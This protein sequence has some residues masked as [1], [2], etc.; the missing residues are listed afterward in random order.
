MSTRKIIEDLIERL[1]GVAPTLLIFTGPALAFVGLLYLR[2]PEP[3]RASSEADQTAA[4]TND[5]ASVAKPTEA[6]GQI[7]MLEPLRPRIIRP[8]PEKAPEKTVARCVLSD[9]AT[10]I[11]TVAEE[12]TPILLG[13][14]AAGK[15]LR[16]WSGAQRFLDPRHDLQI[17]EDTGDWV[18]VSVVS[19]NWPPGN[20]GWT[21]WIERKKIQKVETAEAK[22]CL[23]VDPGAWSGLPRAVQATAKTAALQIL[24]QDERCKRISRGGFLGN[25]QRFY[26]TCYPSDGAKPYHY[27]LSASN[28]RRD[29]TPV[30][31]IDE[32]S[33]MRKCRAELQKTLSG[34]ALI[35]GKALEEVLIDNY[36]SRRSGFVYQIG[37]DFRLGAVDDPQKSF[38]LVSPGAGA[39]ITLGDPS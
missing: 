7:A 29:F 31:L 18:R 22:N 35:E 10:G 38:C 14:S 4:R 6:D 33:A 13:P 24:R 12:D 25:G 1:L 39:E 17:L 16:D 34:R 9:P 3:Q 27:W 30:A 36:Q 21:G 15:P 19:P 8:K 26:L 20:V 2:H 5:A 28:P 37:I 23:F 11:V 32:D